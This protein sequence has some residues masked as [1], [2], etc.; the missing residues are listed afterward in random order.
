MTSPDQMVNVRYLVDNVQ[1]AVDF[2][3]SHLGFTVRSSAAPA[4][5]IELFQ[6]A[7]SS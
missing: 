5:A 1:T 6:P 2:Y 7:A 4:F 3:T